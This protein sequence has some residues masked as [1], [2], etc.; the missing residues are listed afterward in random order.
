[1][2]KI[3]PMKKLA[4]ILDDIK[5]QLQN[6]FDIITL[7]KSKPKYNPIEFQYSKGVESDFIIIFSYKPLKKL[8]DNLSF[9][10]SFD[11][12]ERDENNEVIQVTI[13]YGKEKKDIFSSPELDFL[14][15][16]NQLKILNKELKTMND[17][18]VH[19][20]VIE[21][22]KTIFNIHTETHDKQLMDF[23]KNLQNELSLKR[24]ELGL[25]ELEKNLDI[26][27]NEYLSCLKKIAQEIEQSEEQKKV[28]ELEK[29]LL[30][31]QKN[32]ELFKQ[33]I[34][35]KYNKENILLDGKQRDRLLKD[36][37]N[38]LK[39]YEEEQI[40]SLSNINQKKI[41]KIK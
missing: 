37:K 38:K 39:N 22:I 9:A 13:K 20:V 24:K 35:K 29:E 14:T 19:M 28:K 32:L 15:F 17:T 23:W 41:L 10:F 30:I 3:T 2:K 34:E 40:K 8:K 4:P 5:L 16:K 11:Y 1:M 25:E 26:S 12:Q 33:K 7:N 18:N 31:A 21:K 6:S 27:K 36:A